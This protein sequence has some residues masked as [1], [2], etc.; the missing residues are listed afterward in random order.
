M[1]SAQIGMFLSI[2]VELPDVSHN[3]LAFIDG[4]HLKHIFLSLLKNLSVVSKDVQLLGG[5]LVKMKLFRDEVGPFCGDEMVVEEPV[6][7]IGSDFDI[8]CHDLSE[9]SVVGD[10]VKIDHDYV[11]HF[12]L[13]DHL[14][15]VHV[16]ESVQ[17]D[18]GRL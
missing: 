18:K 6:K 9:P 5:E 17:N 4:L 8:V 2:H 13:I 15:Y 14:R 16:A 10:H 3:F 12:E 11:A 7:V 1:I